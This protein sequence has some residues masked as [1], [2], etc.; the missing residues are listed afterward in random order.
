M[1]DKR[2]ESYKEIVESLWMNEDWSE[3]DFGLRVG[4]DVLDRVAKEVSK[5]VK[6]PFDSVRSA[7][8]EAVQS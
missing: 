7:I 5:K 8:E 3:T 1:M 2:I 6:E 4:G